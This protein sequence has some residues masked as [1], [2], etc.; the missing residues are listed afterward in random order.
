MHIDTAIR[1]LLLEPMLNAT[2]HKPVFKFVLQS[3]DEARDVPAFLS[4]NHPNRGFKLTLHDPKGK[5]FS[6]LFT[7]KRKLTPDD[8]VSGT[9]ILDGRLRIKFPQLYRPTTSKF[10]SS[11]SSHLSGELTFQ[12]IEIPPSGTDNQTYE[13]IVARL[14]ALNGRHPKDKPNISEKIPEFEHVVIIPSAKLQY[15]NGQIDNDINHPFW[16]HWTESKGRVYGGEIWDGEY[17][18]RE[19]GKHLMIGLKHSDTCPDSAQAKL[20]ALYEAVA[21]SHAFQPWP[22][23]RL[24][25]QNGKVTSQSLYAG[26]HK[27]GSMRPL[28]SR[29]WA[30]DRDYPHN[31]IKSVA[32]CFYSLE[33][34][35]IETVRQAL[36]IFRSADNKEA[37]L[38]LQ[39]AMICGVVE[40]L[41]GIL[42]PHSENVNESPEFTEIKNEMM[43][44]QQ[45]LKQRFPEDAYKT[46]LNGLRQFLGQW[47]YN[48][49]TRN[50]E[51]MNAFEPLFPNNEQYIA[52]QWKNF[53]NLRHSVAHGNYSLKTDRPHELMDKVGQMAAFVNV[54]IA[55]KS[56][57]VGMIR[58][59]VWGDERIMLNTPQL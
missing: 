3:D 13:E 47:K 17:S 21:Y 18:I 16:G 5:G 15:A 31:L 14:D 7:N 34:A 59:N 50:Q 6:G 28:N 24:T 44:W 46:Q 39:Q 32:E 52:N 38:P 41:L 37:P 20:R 36:W 43:S 53:Q 22:A 49:E 9:G 25:R 48:H 33:G 11:D 42:K 2:L 40:S 57:Y 27:Q 26:S 45:E 19:Y 54:V 4:R 51:W 30:E 58:T 12:R 35:T 23:Y 8:A 55:A 1:E 56:G 29:D 10:I